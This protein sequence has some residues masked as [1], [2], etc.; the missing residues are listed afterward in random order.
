MKQV[1][2]MCSS[3]SSSWLNFCLVI[4]VII[5]GAGDALADVVKCLSP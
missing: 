3:A 2:Q 5:N 4:M 1:V